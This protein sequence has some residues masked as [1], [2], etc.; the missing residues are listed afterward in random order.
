[1]KQK[2]VCIRPITCFY[3]GIC[4][5]LVPKPIIVLV[6]GSVNLY[7][8]KPCTEPQNYI[9]QLKKCDIIPLLL[10]NF[11]YDRFEYIPSLWRESVREVGMV[12]QGCVYVLCRRIFY[13]SYLI[14]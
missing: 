1:M 2:G 12:F 5:C 4:H 14:E 8:T 13:N 6:H 7:E 3:G 11:L 10:D 9:V